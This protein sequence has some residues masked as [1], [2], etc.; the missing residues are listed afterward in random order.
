MEP[1][2]RLTDPKE[3]VAKM[4]RKRLQ[5][6]L[7]AFAL[8]A[9]MAGPA[10]ANEG[11]A[12]D[13]LKAL[14]KVT[15]NLVNES[16]KEGYNAKLAVRGG[17]SRKANHELYSTTVY[18]DYQGDIRGNV[19][20]VPEMQVFRTPNKGAVFDGVN[21]SM[22]QARAE[23]KQLDRLFAFPV[24]LLANAIKKPKS[25][26]WLASTE[27]PIVEE[28]EEQEGHTSVAKKLTVEQ[29][30]HRLRVEVPDKEALQY[31]VEVQNSGCLDGG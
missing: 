28:S 3:G 18:A 14:K 12:P 25:V 5:V 17:L 26:E 30:Y 22:L 29:Q 16:K 27:A 8:C 23:G 13:P 15:K 2:F 4:H 21:W 6:G 31:F 19:M 9:S 1:G 10:L 20:H 24:H 7:V 11:K